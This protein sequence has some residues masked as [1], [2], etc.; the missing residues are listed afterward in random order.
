M[1]RKIYTL[2]LLGLLLLACLGFAVG[3][4]ISS[5]WI[6]KSPKAAIT[7]SLIAPL[8][9]DKD[10]DGLIGPVNRVRTET[11]KLSFKSGKLIEAPRE[12]LELTTYDRNGQRIDNSYYL[13]NINSQLGEEEYAR[14]E[15]GNLSEMTLRGQ[16]REILRKEVYT[17]EYDAIGNWTKMV[18]STLVYEEGK[19]T[20]QPSEIAYRNITYYFDQA[21]ADIVKSDSS[22]ADS[23][24]ANKQTAQNDFASLRASFDAWL[25]ATNARDLERLL[26]FY[27][28]QME[29]FYR[30]RNVSQD[31]VRADRTRLFERAD[32]LEVKTGAPEITV[33]GDGRTATMSFDKE[34]FMRVGERE[35]RGKVIQQLRW[36]LTSEGWKIVSERDIK[37]LARS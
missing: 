33:S 18:T 37:V 29:A 31:V 23:A 25:A 28:P 14:D 21:I 7:A 22:K 8:G 30:A 16:N 13:V 10:G 11:A 20:Q 26:K 19:V 6:Q 24:A 15:R 9:S 5:G 17:Y 34:Y 12:L 32:A 2:G 3:Y 1:S 36:Q 27:S 4:S 35:R